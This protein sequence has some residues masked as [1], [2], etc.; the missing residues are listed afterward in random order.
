LLA[1]VGHLRERFLIVA[2]RARGADGVGVDVR[3]EELESVFDTAGGS[4]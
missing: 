1:L 3:G 4:H 2:G